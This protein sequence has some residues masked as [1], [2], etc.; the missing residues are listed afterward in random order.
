MRMFKHQ[1]LQRPV[2]GCLGVVMGMGSCIVQ[3]EG[4]RAKQVTDR[5]HYLM[6]INGSVNDL[7]FNIVSMRHVLALRLV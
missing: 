5:M 1:P 2:H 7:P 3:Q 4:P 6:G